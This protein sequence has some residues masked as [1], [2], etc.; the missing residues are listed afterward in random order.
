MAGY[1]TTITLTEKQEKTLKTLSNSRTAPLN[2]QQRAMMIQLCEQGKSN[3]TIME[4]TNI[5]KT[6]VSK[7]RARWA[8]SK[9]KLR[10]IDANEHGIAYQRLIE[11]VLSDALRSG[12]PCKFTA[13]QI[14][15]IIN[16]ACES[17]MENEL[18]FSHWSLSSLAY[19][20]NKRN[21]VDSISTS[22]LQVFLKSSKYKTS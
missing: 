14:C 1:A 12:K 20:L 10:E 16:V 11:K 21:I 17:P 3:K 2:L 6:T 8:A 19:E 18:P 15:Q 22:H 7:W 5:H 13:E 4:E 9:Q